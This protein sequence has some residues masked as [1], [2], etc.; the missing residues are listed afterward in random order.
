MTATAQ[1]HAVRTLA[2][3]INQLNGTDPN[4][5][6]AGPV[7]P[8]GPI[9]RAAFM[10]LRWVEG[11]APDPWAPALPPRLA[12][13]Q[14]LGQVLVDR[15]DAL[16]DLALALP[17]EGRRGVQQHIA[18]VITRFIDDCGNG[19]I[20]IRIPKHGPWPPSDDE[21]KPITPEELLLIGAQLAGAGAIHPALPEAGAKL[22]TVGLER[23]S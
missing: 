23:L 1:H 18:N 15:V 11:P 10:R 5:D 22:M 9:I 6:D 12:F 16:Q 19:R 20:V 21:P 17:E 3:F 13:A 14:A 8:W 2:S 4:P 7:G